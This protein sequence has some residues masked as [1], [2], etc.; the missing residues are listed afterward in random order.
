MTNALQ[1][2]FMQTASNVRVVL[3]LRLAWEGG[4]NIRAPFASCNDHIHDT[5][6]TPV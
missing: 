4:G 3:E 1:V 5:L 2:P 6:T